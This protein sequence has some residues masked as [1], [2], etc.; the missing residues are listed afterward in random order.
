MFSEKAALK[1]DIRSPYFC[2]CN[3]PQLYL[4]FLTLSVSWGSKNNKISI[5]WYLCKNQ[6][7]FAFLFFAILRKDVVLCMKNKIVTY[8]RSVY[9]DIIFNMIF[10]MWSRRNKASTPSKPAVMAF[11]IYFGQSDGK[12]KSILFWGG[13]ICKNFFF[14]EFICIGEKTEKFTSTNMKSSFVHNR[15]HMISINS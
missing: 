13:W 10:V 2:F 4:S 11:M 14:C 12:G 3:F 1:K 7:L 6:K 5:T 8:W 9:G 15:I